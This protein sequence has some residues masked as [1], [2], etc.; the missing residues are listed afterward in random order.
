[1]ASFL[2]RALALPPSSTDWFTD[3]D[4]LSHEDSINRLADAG[5]TTGCGGT[6][7][8]P[9]GLVTRQQMAAFLFRALGS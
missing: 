6:R 2:S 1:M 3:D 5:I 9:S 8:C 7:F 4:G